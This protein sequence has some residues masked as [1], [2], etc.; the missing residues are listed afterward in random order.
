MRKLEM[1]F[2]AEVYEF[3]TRAPKLMKRERR[4]IW[5]GGC[6]AGGMRGG[7]VGGDGGVTRD[8]GAAS[9]SSESHAAGAVAGGQAA[10]G[11]ES[12]WLELFNSRVTLDEWRG[13]EL[14]VKHDDSSGAP[15][16]LSTAGGEIVMA[17]DEEPYMGELTRALVSAGGTGSMRVLEIGYGLGV[18]AAAL[19]SI[20]WR[21]CS[22]LA[23]FFPLPCFPCLVPPAALFLLPPCSLYVETYWLS[24]LTLRELTA[25]RR[26]LRGAGRAAAPGDRAQPRC[27]QCVARSREGRRAA[28]GFHAAIRVLAGVRSV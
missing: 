7:G 23:A 18:R 27:V 17:R 22:S 25:E 8:G 6:T 10:G 12:Q 26:P 2:V 16:H 5:A 28:H 4:Q 19:T 9:V 15:S 20:G 24:P 13:M 11:D 21:C 14:R 1:I 3:G